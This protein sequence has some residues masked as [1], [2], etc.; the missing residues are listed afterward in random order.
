M[1]KNKKECI[2]QIMIEFDRSRS[3]VYR[4]LSKMKKITVANNNNFQ[5]DAP[6]ENTL[7][8]WKEEKRKERGKEV[9]YRI[10]SPE[11]YG[12]WERFKN[13]KGNKIK[14]LILPFF[15]YENLDFPSTHPDFS[16]YALMK[17]ENPETHEVII[18]E[19]Q[20]LEIEI[21]GFTGK[22]R[23]LTKH[24]LLEIVV[25]LEIMK[26]GFFLPS[27]LER[28][29][30]ILSSIEVARDLEFDFM[31]PKINCIDFILSF[32]RFGTEILS[33]S[34]SSYIEHKETKKNTLCITFLTLFMSLK[35]KILMN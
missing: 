21:C 13:H 10:Y 18:S 6:M 27:Q 28:R 24:D 15:S 30:K 17:T 25:F 31:F 26:E 29:Q 16:P 32:I 5:G 35:K 19:D 20:W 1:Y 2:H 7:L 33:R 23:Y 34:T 11:S 14:G 8:E 22:E 9:I 12:M 4:N 3:T